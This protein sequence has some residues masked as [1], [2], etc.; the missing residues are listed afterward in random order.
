MQCVD[1]RG[2]SLLIDE[3]SPQRRNFTEQ[4]MSYLNNTRLVFSGTFQ[5]DVSTVNNVPEA[6]RHGGA[7]HRARKSDAATDVR[8]RMCY[9]LPTW[10]AN[11]KLRSLS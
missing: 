11:A 9:A 10:I 2:R 4:V 7:S 1:N 5:A 6:G 3:D 8:S